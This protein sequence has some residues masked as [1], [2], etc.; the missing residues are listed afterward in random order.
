MRITAKGQ[1]TIP[2][3]L[4]KLTGLAPGTE[5]DC[6]LDGDVVRLAPKKGRGARL[7]ARLRGRGDVRMTTD[8]IM[9]MTRGP[10]RSP[11]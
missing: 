4:R 6:W 7:V 1:V 5:V 9:A 8:Q 2:A 11:R 3:K 10:K